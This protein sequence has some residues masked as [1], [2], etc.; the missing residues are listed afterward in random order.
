M[1]KNV[2]QKFNNILKISNNKD[3]PLALCDQILVSGSNFFLG[4]VIL[5]FLGAETFGLF[6]FLWLLVLLFNSLQLALIINPLLSI[7]PKYTGEN[8]LI[9][10]SSSIILQLILSFI[11]VIFIYIFL[12]FLNNY[13]SDYDVS[14]LELNIVLLVFFQQNQNFLKRLYFS[15]SQYLKAFYQ[16][17][18][19]IITLYI[20]LT[21]FIIFNYLNLSNLLFSILI[22]N[23]IG[24]IYGFQFSIVNK[25]NFKNLI[26]TSQENWKISKWLTLTSL[27]QWFGQNLW[28]ING[29]LYLG[30]YMFGV[31][32][33][34]F[35]IAN[36]MST[37][38]Q[39][40]DNY[41]PLQVTKIFKE[42]GRKF[43]DIYLK[44]FT[45]LTLS[46]SFGLF[47]SILI[48]SKYILLITYG[49]NFREFY[50]ILNL[51]TF[52][53]LIASLQSPFI[54]RMRTIGNTKPIFYSYLITLICSILFS[55]LIISTWGIFGLVYG[56]M[57]TWLIIIVYMFYNFKI[58]SS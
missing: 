17:I 43:M 37:I 24:C 36:V 2:L 50:Y 22:A 40:F 14:G 44:K 12:K 7:S 26:T 20:T 31:Y 25:I 19:T 8:K 47:L 23:F 16:T 51:V 1:L 45:L 13:F 58:S 35:N 28:Q 39:S 57:I 48:F 41:I 6:S 11:F 38:F 4:I 30:P 53:A 3:Y 34:C 29:A 9:Y 49:I 15:T 27:T 52:T 18:I 55:K 46:I 10:L 32:R 33:A 5:R 54:Y 42:K 21:I 56:V